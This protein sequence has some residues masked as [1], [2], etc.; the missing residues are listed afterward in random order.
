MTTHDE[1]RE[2]LAREGAELREGVTLLADALLD[3]VDLY[4]NRDEDHAIHAV[5]VAN[6]LFAA[7]DRAGWRKQGA[8]DLDADARADDSHALALEA[9]RS[10]AWK[11]YYEAYDQFQRDVPQWRAFFT[12]HHQH[13][14]D[15]ALKA[16]DP[17][18]RFAG[19]TGQGAADDEPHRVTMDSDGEPGDCHP[20]CPRCATTGAAADGPA[21]LR[22]EN[23]RLHANCLQHRQEAAEYHSQLMA[24]R[25]DRDALQTGINEV[26]SLID[27]WDACG[28]VTLQADRIRQE[29]SRVSQPQPAP[30]PRRFPIGSPEPDDVEAVRSDQNGVVFQCRKAFPA[31]QA[32]VAT[33]ASG[34]DGR[35]YSWWQINAENAPQGGTSLTEV[36][37]PE[38]AQ[39]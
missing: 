20:T 19:E 23:D 27:N 11:A 36:P 7:L 6:R 3:E 5:G 25:R 37:R 35:A 31:P 30:E 28:A 2:E 14:L 13:A 15:A 34:G 17:H 18:E 32:W 12:A 33:T 29:L 21:R 10:D 39:Q 22:A 9:R 38:G 16:Y 4:Q 24:T 8:P 26:L 1:Q